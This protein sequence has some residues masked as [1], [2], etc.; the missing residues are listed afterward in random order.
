MSPPRASSSAAAMPLAAS[1][2]ASAARAVAGI[3]AR[4][5]IRDAA[6]PSPPA[7]VEP[8]T[9]GGCFLSRAL[10]SS[11]VGVST[12]PVSS[13]RK[14]GGSRTSAGSSETGQPTLAA[15]RQPVARHTSAHEHATGARRPHAASTCV[16]PAHLQPGCESLHGA[17]VG[18]DALVE[19]TGRVQRVAELLQHRKLRRGAYMCSDA[20]CEPVGRERHPSE[21][22]HRAKRD[23]K[24]AAIGVER[25]SECVQRARCTL[26]SAQGGQALAQRRDTHVAMRPHLILAHDVCGTL[27]RHWRRRGGRGRHQKRPWNRSRNG[28]RYGADGMRRVRGRCGRS[29]CDVRR[30]LVRRP[31]LKDHGCLEL[32]D[33]RQ[34]LAE[35]A[36]EL[37]D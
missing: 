8:S 7:A 36:H 30:E 10:T 31:V 20:V 1:T 34:P 22:A 15:C 24:V 23:A 5:T 17:H 21:D 13:S 14:C 19:G 37:D 32:T 16:P 26:E 3:P 12:A 35:V 27:S 9:L 6:S 11:N 18:T 33:R 4:S 2:V 25:G 28:T 29:I